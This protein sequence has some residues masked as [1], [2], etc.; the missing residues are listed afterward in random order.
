MFVRPYTYQTR[1]DDNNKL[2][3]CELIWTIALGLPRLATSLGHGVH[4][5]ALYTCH[6]SRLIVNTHTQYKAGMKCWLKNARHIL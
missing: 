3:P 2:L 1:M 5:C 6:I 4:A